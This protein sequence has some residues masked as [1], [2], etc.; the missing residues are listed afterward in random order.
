M[1]VF[2]G[3]SVT[4]TTKDLNAIDPDDGATDLTFQISNAA[5]GWVALASETTKP[6]QRFTKADLDARRVAF[7]HDGTENSRASF[8]VVVADSKGATSGV[9]AEVQIDVQLSA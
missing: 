5:H 9:P 7:V 6:I 1:S 4:I 2:R 8:S 3:R